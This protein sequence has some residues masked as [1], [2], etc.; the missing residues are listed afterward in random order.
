MEYVANYQFSIRINNR[1]PKE[2][3]NGSPKYAYP[4]NPDLQQTIMIN[5]S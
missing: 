4:K 5:L 2:F 3:F 1:P